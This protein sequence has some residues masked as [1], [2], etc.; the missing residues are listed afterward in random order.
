MNFPNKYQ[1]PAKRVGQI[2]AFSAAI[3]CTTMLTLKLGT[4][5]STSTVAFIFLIIVVLSAFFGNILVAIVTSIVATLCFDYFFFPPF[6]TLNIAAVPDWISLVAFLLTSVIISRLTASAAENKANAVM[7]DDSLILLKKFGS[8]L[9]STPNDQLTLSKIAQET[10]HI[11]SLQYC[12]IHV[13]GVG[14]WHHFAGASAASDIFQ[15]IENQIDLNRDHTLGLS[16]IVDENLL[17]V[18]Y[19]KINEDSTPQSFFVVKTETL[20][21]SVIGAI[22]SMIGVRLTEIMKDKIG[23]Q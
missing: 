5:S 3:L 1:A 20:S 9:T 4:I 17:G 8:W 11:F 6:G 13:Y 14:K 16:E 12:S 22:A 7:L 19:V 18:Q 23:A 15:T 21:T 2:I 10:L